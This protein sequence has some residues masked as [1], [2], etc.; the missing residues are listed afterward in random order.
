NQRNGEGRV[1]RNSRPPSHGEIDGRNN[2]NVD[3][4]GKDDA[5]RCRRQRKNGGASGRQSSNGK[6]AF[7]FQSYHQ[8][9]ESEQAIVDPCQEGKFKRCVSDLKSER[10]LPYR[11][12]FVA[13]R[14]VCEAKGQHDLGK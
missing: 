2:Q 12:K 10:S 5:A 7:D 13:D 11:L 14:T 6:F 9:E 4:R 3:Q 1:R 8:K